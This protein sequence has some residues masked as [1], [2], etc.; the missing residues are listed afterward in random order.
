MVRAYS[1]SLP[2]PGRR[3]ARRQA[4]DP[5]CTVALDSSRRNSLVRQHVQPGA[6][7]VMAVPLC[8]VALEVRKRSRPNPGPPL[9][10]P[11]SGPAA[12][13]LASRCVPRPLG[14]HAVRQARGQVPVPVALAQRRSARQAE[15]AP[16]SG[17]QAAARS[18]GERFAAPAADAG[19]TKHRSPFQRPA[20]PRW[21]FSF[22]GFLS[23]R[24]HHV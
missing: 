11:P 10:R 17:R 15:W 16:P 14:R 21:S 20:H 6:R 23:A 3:E 8:I 2:P 1:R 24:M 19:R 12:R 13:C 18:A 22:P 5:S 4:V 7:R 9:E